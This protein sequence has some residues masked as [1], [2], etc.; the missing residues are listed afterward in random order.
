[1]FLPL[2]FKYSQMIDRWLFRTT[3]LE[4]YLIF[5]SF[6]NKLFDARRPWV[7]LDAAWGRC[8]VKNDKCLLCSRSLS[9]C[10]CLSPCRGTSLR[11]S[12]SVFSGCPSSSSI[13]SPSGRGTT[14]K[15]RSVSS[16]AARL[17]PTLPAGGTRNQTDSERHHQPTPSLQFLDTSGGFRFAEKHECCTH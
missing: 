16:E 6:V 17:S 8:R 9:D 2:I 7:V 12:S 13:A 3:T 11:R 15:K 5:G 4:S 14:W 1:M 10:G